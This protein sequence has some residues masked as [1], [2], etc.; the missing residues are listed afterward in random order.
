MTQSSARSAS[1]AA[2]TWID[3]VCDQFEADW[4]GGHNP[5]IEDVLANL[6]PEAQQSALR[7]LLGVEVALRGERGER[8]EREE[9]QKRFPTSYEV[10]DEFNAYYAGHLD[11][12]VPLNETDTS[13]NSGRS[14]RKHG[15]AVRGTWTNHF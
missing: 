9:Y 15:A 10:V 2:L 11:A 13:P 1:G 7:E 8:I 5:R 14:R 3:R 6:P 12:T 4:R